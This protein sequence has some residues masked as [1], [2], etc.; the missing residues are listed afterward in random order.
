MQTTSTA[1]LRI[2]PYS[3]LLE[4]VMEPQRRLPNILERCCLARIQIKDNLIGLREVR[5]MRTPEVEFDGPL[6]SEPDQTGCVVD[7][8]QRNQVRARLRM[9][10]DSPEP[11][12][13][14]VRAV[15]Q[16]VRDSIYPLGEHAQRHRTVFEIG[17]HRVRDLLVIAQHIAFREPRL[18]PVEFLKV[19]YLDCLAS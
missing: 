7:Q 1:G 15:A 17:E 18:W 10:H 2:S 8:W 11:L 4:L 12:G 6:V 3:C 9:I 5:D 16:V 13:S 14:I 19:R